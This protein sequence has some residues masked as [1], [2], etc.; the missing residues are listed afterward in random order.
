M[1]ILAP[2]RCCQATLLVYPAALVRAYYSGRPDAALPAQRDSFGT[3]GHHGSAIDNVLNQA[4][5]V[6]TAQSICKNRNACGI[7]GPLFIGIDTHALSTPGADDCGRGAGRQRRDDD[8][9]FRGWLNANTSDFLRYPLLQPVAHS[10][11]GR[12]DRYNAVAQLPRPT[13]ASSIIRRTEGRPTRRR[14]GRS[15]ASSTNCWRVASRASAN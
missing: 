5:I 14:R 4:H 1:S 8:G 11:S 9:R 2:A 6:A 7:D 13:G 12:R 15:S 3:S 10:R